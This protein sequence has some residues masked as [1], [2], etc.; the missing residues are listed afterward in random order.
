MTTMRFPE[1][2]ALLA[3]SAIHAQS[4]VAGPSCP[5]KTFTEFSA[6]YVNSAEIQKT[7][8]SL[9]LE[10]IRLDLS[11]PGEPQPIRTTV[12]SAEIK[13]PLFLSLE[14]RRREGWTVETRVSDGLIR[15]SKPNTGMQ[16][17][18]R[19]KK[20]ACWRLVAIEDLS[21]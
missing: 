11:G 19:F 12:G 2:M 4:A 15:L 18:Y 10:R 3:A 21:T 6:L 5:A 7:Y 8:L 16:V 13:F 17:N 9:P 14:Q 1:V 20:D